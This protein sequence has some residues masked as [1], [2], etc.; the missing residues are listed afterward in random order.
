YSKKN[1]ADSSADVTNKQ[2]SKWQRPSFHA[3]KGKKGKQKSSRPGKSV[4]Q[5]TRT[6][7]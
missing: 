4:R 2:S 5:K 1:T 3:Q 6:K 7:K